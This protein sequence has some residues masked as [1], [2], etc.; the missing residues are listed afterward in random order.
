VPVSWTVKTRN[1]GLLSVGS[2]GGQVLVTIERR[3]VLGE[4]WW[5]FKRLSGRPVV[6]RGHAHARYEGRLS[7]P[8]LEILAWNAGA[9]G[10]W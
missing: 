3:Q 4:R 2:P 9:T 7:T 5:L 6:K 1:I 8:Q 10:S